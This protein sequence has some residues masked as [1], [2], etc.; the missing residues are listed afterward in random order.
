MKKNLLINA[1]LV[2]SWHRI[3]LIVAISLQLG[4]NTSHKVTADYAAGNWSAYAG[5]DT[6]SRYS[7]LTQ[8]NKQNVSRLKLTWTYRSGDFSDSL[9]T[10]NECNPVGVNGVLYGSTPGL[11][12]IA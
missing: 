2:L 5:D 7:T 3:L 10:T 4:C 9:K 8:I 11:K 1:N 12:L 6:K